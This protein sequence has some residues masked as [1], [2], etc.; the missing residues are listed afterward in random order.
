MVIVWMI[1]V[2]FPLNFF[3]NA[4]SV[5]WINNSMF[6]DMICA[7][8]KHCSEKFFKPT[9]TAFFQ[10]VHTFFSFVYGAYMVCFV[11]FLTAIV[12]G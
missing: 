5:F 10:S 4:N 8:S 6:Q 7:K 11:S 9:L 3:K 2:T 12:R 1:P